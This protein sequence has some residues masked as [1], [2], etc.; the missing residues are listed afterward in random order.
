MGDPLYLGDIGF[1]VVAITLLKVVVTFVLLLVS[2][3]AMVWFE[4][5]IIADMQ[6]RIGPLLALIPAFLMFSVIPIGGNFN[7]ADGTISIFGHRTFVQ[8]ADPPIGV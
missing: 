7:G 3:M 2:V 4:R 1:A 5:K 6:H 8:L